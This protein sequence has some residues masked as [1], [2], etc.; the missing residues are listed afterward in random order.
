MSHGNSVSTGMR[1]G[2][3][4]MHW[5]SIITYAYLILGTIVMF[6]PVLWL[7]TSSFK[8]PSELVKF[9]PRFLPYR[10]ETVMVDGYEKPLPLYKV[11]IDGETKQLAQVRRV[12]I[13]A[14]MIDPANPTGEKIKVN[15]DDRV[16]IES[17]SFNLD[18]YI[19]GIKSFN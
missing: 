8:T 16:P 12:G 19:E 6:G 7:L 15:I 1:H 13:Q 14:Q 4:T 18:N 10:Q 17:L 5:S 3:E 11:T 2:Q 9:P